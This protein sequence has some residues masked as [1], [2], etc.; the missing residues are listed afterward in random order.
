MVCIGKD[1]QDI[2]VVI[3]AGY[4]TFETREKSARGMCGTCES[5]IS[6]IKVFQELCAEGDKKAV[7]HQNCAPESQQGSLF[8]VRFKLMSSAEIIIISRPG[9]PAR[10]G[11]GLEEGCKME[12]EE[13]TDCKKKLEEQQKSLQRQ[14]RDIEKFASMDPVF[15]D[16][17]KEVWQ[18]RSP[19]LQSL[20]DKQRNHPKNARDCEEEMQ[21]LRDALPSLIGKVWRL[22]KSGTR[23]GK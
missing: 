22:S 19:K 6:G 17:Q 21:M 1:G 15:R 2:D 18:K 7:V 14:L 16:R 4:A 11:S 9:E 20:C 23:V 12:F 10:R 3:F 13:E 5:D 8:D